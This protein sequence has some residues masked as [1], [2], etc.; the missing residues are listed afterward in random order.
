MAARFA[1]LLTEL[2]RIHDIRGTIATLW[3][4]SNNLRVV[5]TMP[6]PEALA[7]EEI[8]RQLNLA[9]WVVQTRKNLTLLAGPWADSL[10]Q[11][12]LRMAFSERLSHS[13]S[14]R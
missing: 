10:R 3:N 14:S 6:D 8:D 7:R 9:G 4:R 12:I 11:S 13:E 2:S 5:A 1:T